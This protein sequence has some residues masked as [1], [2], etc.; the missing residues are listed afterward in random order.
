M[1]HF[2]N[3]TVR[4]TTFKYSEIKTQNAVTFVDCTFECCFLNV[5][6]EKTQFE[7]CY[8]RTTEFEGP[9]FFRLLFFKGSKVAKSV[10]SSPFEINLFQSRI[11]STFFTYNVKGKWEKSLVTYS[12]FL[13]RHD[14]NL[15]E[16]RLT[17]T[18]AFFDCPKN[19]SMTGW[20]TV[21][22][23][24][25]R[26]LCKLYIP[27][28]AEVHKGLI[29]HRASAAH[30]TGFYPLEKNP[31]TPLELTEPATS[32]WEN[33]FLYKKGAIVKP[34]LPYDSDRFETCSSGI[35][36]FL[37]PEEAINYAIGF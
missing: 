14:I 35:H 25:D 31:K 13:S 10:F 26:I 18:P 30:V 36:F 17:E 22:Y 29:K 23:K 15:I 27:H 20:K 21:L 37:S 34:T 11:I 1:P 33:T 9:N 28:N 6:G 8:I 7:D 12:L 19:T 5:T 3:E 32:L 24:G 2:N 4:N 16:T